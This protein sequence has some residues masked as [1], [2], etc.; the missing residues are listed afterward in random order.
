[1]VFYEDGQYAYAQQCYRH[2]ILLKPKHHDAHNNLGLLLMSQGEHDLA[3]VELEH[4][5]ELK[6]TYTA[7]MTNRLLC[8]QYRETA[9]L[10]SLA[11]LHGRWE[12]V[13]GEPLRKTW[14][15][16]DN[17]PDPERRLRLGFVS[18]DLGIHPVGYLME[19]VLS[20]LDPEQFETMCYSHRAA[21]DPT[22]QHLKALAHHWHDILGQSDAEL[23][24]RIRAD[25]IDILFDLA[26]HTSTSRLGAFARKPAPIQITWL[27]YVGTT[28]LRSIDYL[29][30]DGVMVPPEYEPFYSERILRLPDAAACYRLPDPLPPLE[31]PPVT[32]TG[33]ITFGSFNNLAKITHVIELWCKVLTRIAD[34]RLL[35]KFRGLSDP[36]IQSH[37][38]NLFVAHGIAPDRLAFRGYSP[39]DE[40]LAQYAD[41]DIA[42]DTFHYTGGTT[43]ILALA[44]GVPV[45]TWPRDTVASRQS[46]AILKS[47][48]MLETVASSREQYVELAVDWSRRHA[49]LERWRPELRRR[50]QSSAYTT[51]TAFMSQFTSTLRDVWRRWCQETLAR[52]EKAN[53][54]AHG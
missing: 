5:L 6:P 11:E 48:D 40:M 3:V 41:V 36:A 25:R 4:A 33:T 17:V 52:G 30:T 9:S 27:G 14:R 24:E 35:L 18:P 50:M 15:P 54:A 12:Q 23:A 21:I 45:I 26:G 31:P 2:T 32:R 34:S 29:L 16:H 10:Q 49:D 38:Q 28:G 39:M 19:N 20:G 42:L 1:M 7:A 51:G 47:I 43:T 44:M 53:L 37:F 8:E 46:L 22:T 13:H